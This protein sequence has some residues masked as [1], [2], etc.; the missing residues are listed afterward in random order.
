[1]LKF[2]KN[3]LFPLFST[4]FSHG[5]SF[6][7][8]IYYNH[9]LLNLLLGR[10]IILGSIFEK[11]ENKPGLLMLSGGIV[12]AVMLACLKDMKTEL[13]AVFFGY[14]SSKNMD[15][16]SAE[17]LANYYGVDL[18]IVDLNGVYGS[19]PIEYP[20]KFEKF[21]DYYIPFLNGV[22]V[23][24][25]VACAY[26]SRRRNVIWGLTSNSS[27]YYSDCSVNFFKSQSKTVY[28]GTNS[29]VRLIAPFLEVSK[30]EV[31][32]KAKKLNVPLELTQSCFSNFEGPCGKCFGCIEREHV[33]KFN[34]NVF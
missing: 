20:V 3:Y 28:Y 27:A 19:M 1:M 22:M 34:G 9:R 7:Y 26:Y 33:L 18:K 23:S 12:S 21:N 24:V 2:T 4:I 6:F 17:R 8:V 25:A 16:R 32:R 30:A 31:V 29:N 11:I 5:G 13:Q 14:R 15:R 10:E